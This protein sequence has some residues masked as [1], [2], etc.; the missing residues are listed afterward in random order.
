MTSSVP[1]IRF[2]HRVLFSPIED[3]CRQLRFLAQPL[4]GNMMTLM[5]RS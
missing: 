2:G 4:I 3:F 5:V 1:V